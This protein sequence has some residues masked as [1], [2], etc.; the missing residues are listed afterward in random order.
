MLATL[1]QAY[2]RRINGVFT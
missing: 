1:V 2:L